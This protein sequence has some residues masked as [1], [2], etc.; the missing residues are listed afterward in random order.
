MNPDVRILID[1][2]AYS[3]RLKPY[4]VPNPLG[5]KPD[6][7]EVI[8]EVEGFVQKGPNVVLMSM[9]S[10]VYFCPHFQPLNAGGADWWGC[11][12]EVELGS[13]NVPIFDFGAQFFLTDSDS[14]FLHV[15]IGNGAVG[16]LEAE[17]KSGFLAA[18][19][20]LGEASGVAGEFG[21]NFAQAGPAAEMMT[22]AAAAFMKKMSSSEV[23]LVG[24][25]MKSLLLGTRLLTSDLGLFL[26]SFMVSQAAPQMSTVSAG[27]ASRCELA[28]N[29]KAPTSKAD[30]TKE[31]KYQALVQEFT[32]V[33]LKNSSKLSSTAGGVPPGFFAWKALASVELTCGMMTLLGSQGIRE[34]G[35][36]F[37]DASVQK[38][39]LLQT[40]TIYGPPSS[41]GCS[42]TYKRVAT[43]PNTGELK[44]D[45]TLQA[46]L[47]DYRVST[48]EQPSSISSSLP[49]GTNVFVTCSFT[50]TLSFPAPVLGDI[51]MKWEKPVNLTMSDDDLVK[52]ASMGPFDAL[53]IKAFLN[54][55]AGKKTI[56]Q[57]FEAI[58]QRLGQAAGF[59][60]THARATLFNA[61]G[62]LPG[63]QKSGVWNVRFDLAFCSATLSFL[64]S[65]DVP[66]GIKPEFDKSAK[67]IEKQTTLVPAGVEFCDRFVVTRT[68]DLWGVD[69]WMF[70]RARQLSK[71]WL[72]ATNYVDGAKLVLQG[73]NSSDFDLK[74]IG[75]SGEF[76]ISRKDTT[77]GVMPLSDLKDN[78]YE[79]T[80]V[81]EAKSHPYM[82]LRWLIHVAALKKFIRDHLKYEFDVG[83]LGNAFGAKNALAAESELVAAVKGNTPSGD[84]FDLWKKVIVSTAKV[85]NVSPWENTSGVQLVDPGV[86]DETVFL[87]SYPGVD[88]D[89]LK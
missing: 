36:T 61:L 59:Q 60:L 13:D 44:F 16:K 69:E 76:L 51:S 26:P 18:L 58:R 72:V 23:F 80:Y 15:T 12:A 43:D 24:K 83:Y 34:L 74:M 29:V 25:Q 89:L 20:E 67:K 4:A 17:S 79:K 53:A 56:S 6:S 40:F 1:S 7:S 81:E 68:G 21:I 11:H 9:N 27:S 54:T 35:G 19:L 42:F 48:H 28:L 5:G 50:G 66:V 84:A 32:S 62:V 85:A 8:T 64:G 47:K 33:T 45:G 14:E 22:S 63:A 46:V 10:R 3:Q 71:V 57:R 38:G 55:A 88:F 77:S 41:D 30:A 78:F 82:V 49:D 65:L 39:E 2:F 87:A 31:E 86:G 73:K 70:F 37:V 52:K 75:D